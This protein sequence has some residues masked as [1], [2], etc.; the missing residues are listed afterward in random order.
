MVVTQL[1]WN[2]KVMSN[3]PAQQ[4]CA[5]VL[6]AAVKAKLSQEGVQCPI[7]DSHHSALADTKTPRESLYRDITSARK[8]SSKVAGER[9]AGSGPGLSSFWLYL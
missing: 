4:E 7:K 6:A 2:C 9:D 3:R 1:L 5:S 8:K